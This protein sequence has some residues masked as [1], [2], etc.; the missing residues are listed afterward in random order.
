MLEGIR[1]IT[2]VLPLWIDMFGPFPTFYY[3]GPLGLREVKNW[4]RIDPGFVQISHLSEKQHQ[5]DLQANGPRRS[6]CLARKTAKYITYG[7][8]MK[9]HS[10]SMSS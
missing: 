6:S 4:Y 2:R 9:K 5:E 10:G 1:Y 7:V 8:E 3:D